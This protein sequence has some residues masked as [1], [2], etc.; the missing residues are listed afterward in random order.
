MDFINEIAPYAMKVSK[1]SNVLASVMMA[2]AVLES[3]MGRSVLA[4]E[5]K[6]LFGIKGEYNGQSIEA[7]TTEYKLENGEH[8]PYSITT[9]FRKY[10]SWY[11]SF[12][13]LANKYVNGVSWNKFLYSA[14]VGEKDYR[15]AINIIKNAGYAT[16]PLYV[17]K[18][19]RVIEQYELTKYDKECSNM[20]IAICAGHGGNNST[21]GKRTPDNE[22]EWNFNDK[23]V[24]AFM[25]E[26][27][28][29]EN[30]EVRRMDDATGRTDVSLSTRTNIA[31]AWGAD[32]YISV[33]HNAN[34]GKWGNWT[35]TETFVYTGSNPKSEKLASLIHPEMVKAYGL[36]DRGVKKANLHI[37][38]ETRMPSVLLEGCYMDSTIDIVKLRDDNVLRN[39]GI[40][41]AKA[42]AEYGDLKLKK[43]AAV[44]P[45]PPKQDKLMWGDVEYRKGQIGR[46][47]ILK[48]INL[49]RDGE[50]G[51]LEV[52]KILQPP[53]QYR[54]YGY[55]NDYGGQY[56]LGGGCWLTKMDGYIKYETPSK[57][58]L[59]KA[60]ELY[61]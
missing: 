5:G 41:V 15:N 35:G 49:W 24:R 14:V 55:R 13:D 61:K 10:P 31:N 44:K 16:D 12:R 50:N 38:R 48:P 30:V 51:K 17:A 46:V 22:Y 23:V 11:E 42:V 36:R 1:E 56:D 3:S 9:K 19:I 6:N 40:G 26:I 32:I 8:I 7:K 2:Q 33:H 45:A 25:A 52:V 53:S 27:N 47:T 28:K 20:K 54:V 37:C 21:P 29:Y 57:A 59:A 60:A 43:V 34:T 18:I 39:A 58:L 4:V